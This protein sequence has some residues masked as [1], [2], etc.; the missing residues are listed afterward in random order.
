MENKLLA[1]GDSFTHGDELS[2]CF[3]EPP[4]YPSKLTWPSLLAKDLNLE[5]ISYA[6][7]GCSNQTILRR[8][9]NNTQVLHNSFVIVNW[10]WIDRWDFYNTLD[11]KWETLRPTKTDSIFY[12]NYTK[13]FQSELWDKYETL[14]AMSTVIDLLESNKIKYLMTCIDNL[15]ID[16]NNHNPPYVNCLMEKVKDKITW[17]DNLS[18]LEW[19]QKNNFV[20]SDN[21]HPL[22]EAHKSAF[23]YIKTI[24]PK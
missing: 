11:N 14:K 23:K 3:N 16:S 17:F 20:I 8:I 24:S 7:P 1:F 21:L 6:V 13:Y 9:L 19:S 18:F 5:Y 12:K 15:V 4:Y 2:D 10:T 22:E